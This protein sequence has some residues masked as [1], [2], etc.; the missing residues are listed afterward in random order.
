MYIVFLDTL[1]A[2]PGDLDWLVFEELGE[3]RKHESTSAGQT[4]ERIKEAEVVVTNKVKI[5]AE[6]FEKCPNLKM[7]CSLATGVDHIDMHEAR[8]HNVLVCNVPDYSSASVAQLTFAL[9][10][11]LTHHVGLHADSVKNGDWGASPTFGY[12]KTPLVELNGKTFLVVGYGNI[13]KQVATVAEAFG[14]KVLRVSVRKEGPTPNPLTRGTERFVELKK[15]LSKADIVSVH[16]PAAEETKG[17]I[18]KDWIGSMKPSAFLIN[19]AR[20]TLVNEAELAESLKNEH[21]A[22]YAADVLS[23][24]PPSPGNPLLSAPNC[25]ITPHLAWATTEARQRLWNTCAQNV[26]AFQQGQPQNLVGC[27]TMTM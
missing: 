9:L 24:E 5:T 11:E 4:L 3:V 12:W 23:S 21:I 18:G 25:V 2:N 26:D 6:H 22:G 14:M 8:H 7:V 19:T 13:G 10:L 16:V 17:M 27:D 20:G 15:G 1:P